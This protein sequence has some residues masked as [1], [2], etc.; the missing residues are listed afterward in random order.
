MMPFKSITEAKEAKFPTVAEGLNLSL[1]QVNKLSSINDSIAEV[2][3]LDN[4][5]AAAW[6]AWKKIYKKDGL[7]G[8]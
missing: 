5:M 7:L 8:I 2:G 6:S 1:S 3:E 4:P